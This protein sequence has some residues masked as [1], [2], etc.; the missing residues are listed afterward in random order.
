VLI[1][2]QTTTYSLVYSPNYCITHVGDAKKG[3]V[4]NV[5]LI[6]FEHA[7]VTS[8]HIIMTYV[9]DDWRHYSSAFLHTPPPQKSAPPSA[10]LPPFLRPSSPL[11]PPLLRPSSAPQIRPSSA[12]SPPLLRPKNPG[13]TASILL[14]VCFPFI[15]RLDT[16]AGYEC[17]FIASQCSKIYLNWMQTRQGASE[18]I[19]TMREKNA[20]LVGTKETGTIF[21]Q[22]QA[23]VK[24][25]DSP[26]NIK[27]FPEAVNY[28]I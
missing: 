25:F 7:R 27:L 28:R 4:S 10:P 24:H 8:L 16:Q 1:K 6:V 12:L 11:P 9:N 15:A 20:H 3:V 22:L 19:L 5:R 23:V 14:L 2:L 17:Y 21:R 13:R 18:F 26:K